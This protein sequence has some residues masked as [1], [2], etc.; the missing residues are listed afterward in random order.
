[1]KAVT[2]FIA[3]AWLRVGGGVGVEV[4]VQPTNQISWQ[5]Q[6]HLCVLTCRYMSLHVTKTVRSILA[7]NSM[8][9]AWAVSGLFQRSLTHWICSDVVG[10]NAAL[11]ATERSQVCQLYRWLIKAASNPP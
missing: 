3:L 5:E 2:D 11:S 9:A 6:C 10:C 7:T 8:L 1:M 4:K